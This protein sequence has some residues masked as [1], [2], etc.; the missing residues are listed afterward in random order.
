MTSSLAYFY[1]H[2]LSAITLQVT[3]SCNLRC[4]YCIYSGKYN[5]RTHSGKRMTFEMAKRSIDY[6][7]VH[8]DKSN[9]LEIGF[10]GGEPLLEFD[11]IKKCVE[12]VEDKTVGRN[13]VYGITTNATLLNE[14][15][16]DFLVNHNFRTV[17]SFDGPKEIHDKY[18]KFADS[19]R[20]SF[21]IVMKNVK[22]IKEK[23]PEYFK[24]NM[25]FNTVL[26]PK[27][28][29]SCIGD[30]L[31][32]EELFQDAA[33]TAGIVS[34]IGLKK[35]EKDDLLE[36]YIEEYNYEYF[37]LLLS[38]IGK[39]KN[40]NVSLV[41]GNVFPNLVKIRGGKHREIGKELPDKWHRGG[42]CVP[43]D[44]AVFITVDGDF[45][46]C[47]KVC[48]NADMAVMGNI[49]DGIDVKKAEKILNI[50][51]YTSE[52]CKNCWAYRYCDS[53]IR[54]AEPGEKNLKDKLLQRCMRIKRSLEEDFKD[55][56]VLR[57]IGYDFE[58]ATIK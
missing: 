10:Y 58:Q 24:T 16:I 14:E 3:Q 35:S 41:V 50:E 39:L 53:C 43:G 52:E 40:E 12:Y 2:N 25:V 47:E 36:Q 34:D 30:F 31:Q 32:K 45:Y 11:L 38:K 27:E 26:N 42:P 48:E 1:E 17:I 5:T 57:E 37:K 21:D 56:C 8:S 18:R 4:D 46:P 6:L 13:P 9:E 54:Y 33:F 44:R 51:R 20:G 15:K 7:L 49:W 28:G 29:F 22:H 23:Y 55:Y 19:G